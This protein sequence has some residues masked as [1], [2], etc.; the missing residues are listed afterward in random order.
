M[1]NW[2][3]V[4]TTDD[5]GT[6]GGDTNMAT[7]DLSISNARVHTLGRNEFVINALSGNDSANIFRLIA[8]NTGDDQGTGMEISFRGTT[9][10]KPEVD[11]NTH[12]LRFYNGNSN[13]TGLKASS[14]STQNIAL[15]LPSAYPADGAYL[16]HQ[17]SGQLVWSNPDP[18]SDDNSLSEVDQDIAVTRN[19]TGIGSLSIDLTGNVDIKDNLRLSAPT[20]GGASLTLEDD[21]DDPKTVTLKALSISESFVL[22]LPSSG[23]PILNSLMMGVGS[24][25]T[26]SLQMSRISDIPD[27]SD[28]ATSAGHD[29]VPEFLADPDQ[30]SPDFIVDVDTPSTNT[31]H[32]LSLDDISGMIL[33]GLINTNIANGYGD[34]NTYVDV[35]GDNNVGLTGDL[36]GDGS[37]S[38]ADLLEF[39]TQFSQIDS[40]T[41]DNE[42]SYTPRYITIDAAAAQD[43]SS[44]GEGDRQILNWTNADITIGDG[45]LDTGIAAGIDQFSILDSQYF[46][47]SALPAKKLKFSN[48]IGD[49]DDIGIAVFPQAVGGVIKLEAKVELFG[50]SGTTALGTAGYFELS[51]YDNILTLP[52]DG[53]IQMYV[54]GTQGGVRT[55][56]SEQLY[57]ETGVYWS[58]AAI[59]TIRISYYISSTV[60]PLSSVKI[61]NLVCRLSA[62]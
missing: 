18:G 29:T 45:Q 2:K 8:P 56:T 22:N 28:L 46:D 26:T 5:I 58:N 16:E 42:I 49:A 9:S 51:S 33:L 31:Q 24:S 59:D 10:L 14:A 38:T 43:V 62:T 32:K 41:V 35:G 13:F 23:T 54:S 21:D 47:M 7:H 57:N 36:N 20:A 4:L 15:T 17:G 44:V 1:A 11:A 3:R 61:D 50:N 55:I 27:L 25:T 48:G 19:I 39:L 37:V 60:A 30:V 53:E 6:L 12:E 40:D 34:E 52:A